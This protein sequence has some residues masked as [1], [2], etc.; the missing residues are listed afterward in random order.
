MFSY[1]LFIDFKDWYPGWSPGKFLPQI[2]Y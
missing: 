2:I 1:Q